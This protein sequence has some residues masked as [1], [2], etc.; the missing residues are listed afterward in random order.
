MAAIT[1]T[2]GALNAN[3]AYGLVNAEEQQAYKLPITLYKND[4]YW[5]DGTGLWGGVSIQNTV[6]TTASQDVF[7]VVTVPYVETGS[8]ANFIDETTIDKS[9][10]HNS[11]W[12]SPFEIDADNG[13]L[14]GMPNKTVPNIGTNAPAV[15]VA[16]FDIST[17][18]T[19]VYAANTN[20]HG[21]FFEES[22]DPSITFP[23]FEVSGVHDITADPLD[24]ADFSLFDE[25]M[26]CSAYLMKVLVSGNA[27]AVGFR[28]LTRV[29]FPLVGLGSTV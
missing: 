4:S 14:I 20:I 17:D 22:Q 25:D 2:T 13:R 26:P 10:T 11:E 7:T 23:V 8:G 18:G 9:S 3:D 24:A 5:S 21:F 29:S 15:V 19:S 12:S 16:Q 27:N 28:T 6:I 1:R